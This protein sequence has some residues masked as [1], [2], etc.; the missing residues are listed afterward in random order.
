MNQK[1]LDDTI[2]IWENRLNKLKTQFVNFLIT[3]G[4]FFE[5]D[6]PLCEKYSPLGAEKPCDGCDIFKI[7]CGISCKD[8]TPFKIIYDLFMNAKNYT[9][10]VSELIIPTNN[11]IVFLKKTREELYGIDS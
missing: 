7:N 4:L 8:G 3:P 2:R 5:G 10:E 1:L 6:T 9:I 11:F